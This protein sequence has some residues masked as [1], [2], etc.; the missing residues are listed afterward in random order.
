MS[1]LPSDL[2]RPMDADAL[3]ADLATLAG[4]KQAWARSTPAA[5]IAVL[6]QIKD[7]LITVAETWATTAAKHKLIPADSQHVG[8]EWVSGPYAVMSACNQL[9]ETLSHLDNKAF[10]KGLP[11]RERPDGQVIVRVTPHSVWDSLL[12]SGVEAD[13]WMQPEVTRDTLAANTASAYDS[14][15]SDRDGAVSLILGAGNIAAIA[16]LDCFY[17]LFSEHEVCLLKMN[18][19]N[20]YLIPFLQTAL[21]PLIALDALRI[22]RGGADVGE[23]LC[24]HE[25]IDNIHITGAVTTHDAI[26][27]GTGETAKANRA[28]NT[29]LTDKPVTSELGGVCP[30]IVVP[31]AWSAADIR[32]QAEQIAT[33]KL[34]NSGFNC[35][36]CQVLV[37]PEDWE[38]TD[39]LL[40]AVEDV[41][42]TLPP[43]G[44]YYPGSE[45]RLE[46]F[47]EHASDAKRFDRGD[48]PACVVS[49]MDPNDEWM[50]NNEV[51]APALS[52]VRF[53]STDTAAYIKNAIDWCNNTLNGTLGANI[54]LD[55]KTEKKLGAQAFEDMIAELH[56]GCIAINAWTGLGFLMAQGTWGAFPG[57]TLQDAQSGIGVVH[58]TFLF[59][60][61]ERTVVR[62]PFRPF[63]RTVASG[64]MTMLP[65]PPWFVTNTQQ[66]NIGKALTHFQHHPSWLKIPGVFFYA[67]QG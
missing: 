60:K 48:A 13:I 46:R 36:A 7:A 30:T 45:S 35:I 23:Y 66:H 29:P 41:M 40:A 24:N 42:K 39:T 9:I 58:N 64:G 61:P 44:L 31:G 57:H 25:S 26:V 28:A 20:D 6:K 33:Q 56:Y 12:L 51:F 17:K 10:L 59:D 52:V 53:P 38:H 14:K 16:P 50:A 5:R 18:P 47:A 15:E 43:R 49:A 32:F 1:S 3:D 63:P 34:H 54:L 67:L 62:A 19:V 11:T 22:V 55:P 37:V 4:S 8:E 65:R 27:W 21:A 2:H